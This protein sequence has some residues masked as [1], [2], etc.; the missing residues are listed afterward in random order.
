MPRNVDPGSIKVGK[1][2][3]PE[4]TV[5][6][7]SL[8]YPERDVDPLRV[9]IHDPSRAHMASTIGIV[10]EGDCFVSD[11]VEGALQEICSGAAAGRL[12]GLISGGTFVETFPHAGLT[13]TLV[14]PT[15]I[16]INTGVF[17]AG[18]LTVTLP[19]VDDI[20]FIYLDTDSSSPG[21][22]TLQFTTGAPPE[23]ETTTEIEDVLIAKVEVTTGGTVI[24]NYQDGRFFVRNLDRKVQ[25][26][27]RQGENVDAWSEGCFATLHAFLLWMEY[28]GSASGTGEEQK[29]EVLVR[30]EH[31]L[32]STLIVPTDSLNFV[33]DGN[34]V[35]TT[36]VGFTDSTLIQLGFNPGPG[37]ANILFRNITF[38]TNANGVTGILASNA[39]KLDR[40]RIEDCVFAGGGVTF[41][42]GINLSTPAVTGRNVSITDTVIQSSTRAVVIWGMRDVRITGCAFQ[43]ASALAAG[44]LAVQLGQDGVS[45]DNAYLANNRIEDYETGIFFTPV[46]TAKIADNFLTDVAYGISDTQLY[47]STDVDIH[48]NTIQ[49]DDSAGET[50]MLFVRVERLSI[51]ENSLDCPRFSGFAGGFASATGIYSGIASPALV[52]IKGNQIAGFYDRGSDFGQ[53]IEVASLYSVIEGNACKESGILVQGSMR[54]CSITG[55]SLDGLYGTLAGEYCLLPAIA[56]DP[57]GKSSIDPGAGLLISDNMIRR[58]GDG[59]TVAG[60]D[61][62]NP[63]Q[64]VVI[65]D[66]TITLVAHSGAQADTFADIGT[67]GIGIAFVDGAVIS[68]NHLEKVGKVEDFSGND[69]SQAGDIWALPIYARNSK[70]VTISSNRIAE[71]SSQDSGVAYGI[72]VAAA[73]LAD[74]FIIRDIEVVDNSVTH[75]TPAFANPHSGIWFNTGD[76]TD[77]HSVLNARVAGNFIST[78]LLADTYDYGIIFSDVDLATGDNLGSVLGD[79]EVSNNTVSN[80]DR[81]GINASFGKSVGQVFAASITGCRILDNSLT[82]YLL[83]ETNPQ[84]GVYLSV[85]ATNNGASMIGNQITANFVRGRDV[86]IQMDT[87]GTNACVFGRNSITGNNV[88]S[89]V[90]TLRPTQGIVVTRIGDHSAQTKQ[91]DLT[92][93]RNLIGNGTELGNQPDNGIV[94]QLGSDDFSGL[95]IDS[96][97][98]KSGNDLNYSIAISTALGVSTQNIANVSVTDNEMLVP[99]SS[100]QNYCLFINLISITSLTRAVISG[101]TMRNPPGASSLFGMFFWINNSAAPAVALVSSIQVTD[102]NV[103]GGNLQFLFDGVAIAGMDVSNNLVGGNLVALNAARG[104]IGVSLE[105]TASFPLAGVLSLSIHGNQLSGESYGV[106]Y[107]A[108]GVPVHRDVD[109]VANQITS[110][111]PDVGLSGG[112]GIFF[113]LRTNDTKLFNCRICENQISN[114]DGGHGINTFINIPNGLEI[115]GFSV[116]RNQMTG[117]HT[118]IASGF[119][120]IKCEVNSTSTA[121]I[122]GV[123]IDD[124][125]IDGDQDF[126]TPWPSNGIYVEFP[127]NAP[128]PNHQIAQISVSR[129]KIFNYLVDGGDG[130]GI[131]VRFPCAEGGASTTVQPYTVLN[132]DVNDNSVFTQLAVGGSPGTARGID[133]EL[134]CNTLNNSVSGNTVR[135]KFGDLGSGHGI[136]IHHRFGVTESIEMDIGGFQSPYNG[137]YVVGQTDATFNNTNSD[138]RVG[139][140][141]QPLLGEYVRAVKWQNID[142]SNNSIQWNTPE[143]ILSPSREINQLGA[144]SFLHIRSVQNG[145]INAYAIAVSVWGCTINGN[146]LTAIKDYDQRQGRY[147][148][149]RTVL[150][151]SGY[152]MGWANGGNPAGV[153]LGGPFFQE[154]WAITGNTSARFRSEDG[155]ATTNFYGVCVFVEL[156]LYAS[157]GAQPEADMTDMVVTGNIAEDEIGGGTGRQ[158][159]GWGQLTADPNE[160]AVNKNKGPRTL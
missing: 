90:S 71:P 159:Y 80:Y 96:N 69:I 16:L 155:D 136:R 4:G 116:S 10:D 101:N 18:S 156:P 92:I 93:S 25:Y 149:F 47:T 150:F 106:V 125:I 41:D 34:A 102:N 65:S 14:D 42:V 26:S 128:T 7:N 146:T 145:I 139:T 64:K 28:Y 12:N 82:G 23:V 17:D 67:K 35:I 105:N 58:F 140:P 127:D 103:T 107:D 95:F 120:V 1:G 115:G 51:S 31:V 91:D 119:S 151:D 73:G 132:L 141:A 79:V 76:S 138:Y 111:T 86:G 144:L 55:N 45:C 37:I 30:G 81:F 40:I 87:S 78:I 134:T 85:T 89:L 20:Y 129:N 21:Y 22:K 77:F 50:G 70:G 118:L 126:S 54:D 2:L 53:A 48:N 9:H 46:N 160:K 108:G 121:V 61:V 52:S 62:V 59:I 63:R 94:V 135:G 98:V 97:V 123:N 109:I 110:P 60:G 137:A 154:S 143:S 57:T 158:P 8:R 33:G 39:N 117:P 44:S 157:G 122:S 114:F 66:N 100:I 153:A 104:A 38:Q 130:T 83:D 99:P 72:V 43:G 11:E 13:L 124:N 5:E 32:D 74:P 49:L 75:G 142:V 15:E 148:G 68:G 112:D 133:V 84:I 36:T 29:G 147:I 131:D 152:V 27:S 56:V 24:D 88:T 19:A 3:A 113:T 6:D